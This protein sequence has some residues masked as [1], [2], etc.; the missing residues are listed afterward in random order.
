[1]ESRFYE[2]IVEDGRKQAVRRVLERALE[3]RLGTPCPQAVQ[4]RLDRLSADQLLDLVLAVTAAA[5]LAGVR[6]ALTASLGGGVGEE[7]GPA[8][9]PPGGSPVL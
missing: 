7:A 8:L 1:M 9:N 3:R 4:R 6:H 2:L 5:S